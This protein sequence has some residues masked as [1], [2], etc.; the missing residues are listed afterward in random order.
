[1]SSAVAR[2]ELLL[3]EARLLGRPLRREEDLRLMT[4]RG[5]Y[6]GDI[7]LPGMLYAAFVRSPYARARILGLDAARALRLSGVRLVLTGSD[8]KQRTEL[9]TTVEGEGVKSTKRLALAADQVRYVGEPVALV[10]A[11]DPYL[12]QDAAELVEVSYHPLEPVVDPERALQPGAPRVHE[13]LP[14]N[15]GYYVKLEKG[16]VE[17]AFR[18][19]DHVIKLELVNQLVAPVPLEPRGVV[20]SYDAGSG[21]LTIWLSTQSP[22]EAREELARILRLHES[23]VRVIS[24]DVGGAFGSKITVSPEEV[25]VALASITLG[26]PVKWEESRRENLIAGSHGR[27]Q[28]QYVEAAVRADGRILG[29]RVKIIAD[30]GAYALEDSVL[31]PETTLRMCPGAYDI[32]NFYGEAYAVFTNKVPQ[33]AYRGAGRPEA[34]YLIERTMNAI[35]LR[36]KLDPAMVRL[37]NFVP[38]EKFPYKSAGGFTYDSGDYEANL[39]RALEASG[40]QQLRELQARARAEGRLIGIGISTYVEICGFGPSYPQTAALAVLRSGQVVVHLG[41]NPHGQGH[42]TPFKQLVADELGIPMEDIAVYYGDTSLLPWSTVTA[43]SRSLPVGGSALLLAARKIKQK[44]ARIAA[45]KLGVEDARMVFR[46]GKIFVEGDPSRSISF[47]EVAALAYNPRRLPKGMEP[48]LFAYAA[49]A[50]KNFTFPFGTHVCAVEVDP[51]TGQIRLLKYVAVDD[52][53]RVIN[54]LI[55]EGQVHG[56]VAQGLG[57]ALIE[58]FMYDE[59]GQPLSATLSDYLIPSAEMLPSFEWHTTQTPTDTNP[60]GAKGI[61]ETGTIA[62]TPAVVNAVE[63]ALSHLGILIDRMPL[64]PD[65][66][67]SL[68][69]SG[70]GPLA[71]G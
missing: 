28:K 70:V 5:R 15:I 32:E 42:V 20:A 51:E 26:R 44:M 58:G 22:H 21:Q 53:G 10:V 12:A 63:D 16:D 69:T 62:A 64:T 39:R 6:V 61:G 4:G 71:R 43:G 55:A 2:A 7:R 56:G 60:L 34:T 48:T 23:R 38:R 1:M 36:L 27:G 8:V 33:G 3:E 49:F 35:A 47:K 66:I 14:D 52:V 18:E 25:A 19:A 31:L 11:E 65:Y 30:A 68:L 40:Y 17:G 57:Q 50:P 67:R 46:D 59:Q 13:E 41:T 29:L 54:P 9:L 45:H 24:P 37:V